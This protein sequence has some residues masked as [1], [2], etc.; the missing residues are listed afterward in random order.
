MNRNHVVCKYYD[1]CGCSARWKYKRKFRLLVGHGVSFIFWEQYA[2]PFSV[3]NSFDLTFVHP[4]QSLE[5]RRH[6]GV[7]LLRL[8][9][10][11]CLGTR[12]SQWPP[13]L[14][15]DPDNSS[16]DE[17]EQCPVPLVAMFLRTLPVVFVCSSFVP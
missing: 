8:G 6:L 14:R 15:H 12:G 3:S 4:K 2:E 10:R 7:L 13:Q 17:N 9:I 1:C 11:S 16:C 5:F